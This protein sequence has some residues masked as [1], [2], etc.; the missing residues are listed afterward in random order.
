MLTQCSTSGSKGLRDAKGESYALYNCFS[1]WRYVVA[2]NGDR[3]H[4]GI[5]YSHPAG[6]C[7]CHSAAQPHSGEEIGIVQLHI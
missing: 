5:F 4:G 1:T 7:C 3:I 2:G 6:H